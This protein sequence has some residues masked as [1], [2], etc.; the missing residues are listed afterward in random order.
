MLIVLSRQ[1][2]K[3]R[4]LAVINR[5]SRW[6]FFSQATIDSVCFAAHITVAIVLNGKPSMSLIVPAFIACLLFFYEAVRYITR[7]FDTF[8]LTRKFS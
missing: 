3:S 6:T 1:M 4:T 8:H 7:F 2:A 5:V